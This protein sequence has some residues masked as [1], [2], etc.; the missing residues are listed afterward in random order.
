M[1]D[2]RLTLS[3]L[4]PGRRSLRSLALVGALA[5]GVKLCPPPA[6]ATVAVRATVESLTSQ[7]QLVILGRVTSQWSPKERGPQGQIYTRSAV[8]VSESWKGTA[9]GVITVQQLGGTVDGFTL[10]VAGSPQLTVGEEVVLFLTKG[11]GPE[12]M[13]H[14]LS[15]AQGVYHVSAPTLRSA[16]ASGAIAPRVLSQDLSGITL[17]QATPPSGPASLKT[18]LI[19]NPAPAQSWTLS[20]LKAEVARLTKGAR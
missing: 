13:Y 20:A 16:G 9:P 3:F 4:W 18:H 17:Y 19:H 14:V 15:L 1:T 7:A 11:A 12:A 8:E 2:R 6:S 5:C 10:S